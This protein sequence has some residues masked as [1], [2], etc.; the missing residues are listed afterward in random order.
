M[1]KLLSAFFVTLVSLQANV[2]ACDGGTAGY[3]LPPPLPPTPV[4]SVVSSL[5]NNAGLFIGLALGTLIGAVLARRRKSVAPNSTIS[6]EHP[7]A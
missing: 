1:N 5:S 3:D 2:Y 4:E 7:V 6:I